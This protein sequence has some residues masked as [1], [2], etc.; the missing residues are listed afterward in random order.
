M[1]GMWG[2]GGNKFKRNTGWILACVRFCPHHPPSVT[3]KL[4]GLLFDNDMI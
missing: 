3:P 2:I 4:L 1:K